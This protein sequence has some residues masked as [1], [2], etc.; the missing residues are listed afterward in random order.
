LKSAAGAVMRVC[1][2]SRAGMTYSSGHP[3][4][5]KRKKRRGESIVS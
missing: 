1:D 3:D 4:H 2:A 5:T